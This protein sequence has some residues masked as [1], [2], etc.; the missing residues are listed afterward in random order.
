ML[1]LQYCYCETEIIIIVV[2][3]FRTGGLED[4]D[5][6]NQTPHHQERA[7]LDIRPPSPDGQ[8]QVLHSRQGRVDHQGQAQLGGKRGAGRRYLKLRGRRYRH[9]RSLPAGDGEEG[10]AE[11]PDLSV[12]LGG[13]FHLGGSGRHEGAAFTTYYSTSVCWFSLAFWTDKD[14]LGQ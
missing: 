6:K 2:F 12:P 7:A 11:H 5:L 4:H 8:R 3:L 13:T 9:G 10:E 1:G 14:N